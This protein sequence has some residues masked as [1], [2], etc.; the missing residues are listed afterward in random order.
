MKEEIEREREREGEETRSERGMGWRE[1]DRN[2]EV[3]R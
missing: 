3:E 2:R 1:V